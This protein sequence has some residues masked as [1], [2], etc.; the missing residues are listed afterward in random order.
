MEFKWIL[1]TTINKSTCTKGDSQVGMCQVGDIKVVHGHLTFKFW[2]H[3][4]VTRVTCHQTR[5]RASV[6]QTLIPCVVVNKLIRV[7]YLYSLIFLSAS[8]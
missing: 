2:Q 3:P 7:D 1:N 4:S 5:Y 6:M 8:V